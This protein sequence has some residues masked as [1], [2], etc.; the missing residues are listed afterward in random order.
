MGT[1]GRGRLVG[2]G[3]GLRTG[4]VRGYCGLNEKR[5]MAGGLNCGGRFKIFFVS[6][7]GFLCFVWIFE[8]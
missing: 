2:L 6:F 5:K 1:R 4:R 7:S 3:G 8:G